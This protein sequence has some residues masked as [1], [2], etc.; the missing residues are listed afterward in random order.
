MT[1]SQPHSRDTSAGC[2]LPG[3]QP[4]SPSV[5]QFVYSKAIEKAFRHQYHCNDFGQPS[6]K[7]VSAVDQTRPLTAHVR[8]L[9]EI[10]N[11][12]MV[13][14]ERLERKRNHIARLKRERADAKVQKGIRLPRKASSM[15][16]A[17]NA[18]T[19]VRRRKQPLK[20]PPISQ[21]ELD[22]G[23]RQTRR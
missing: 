3:D 10:Y 7:Q 6:A 9:P 5:F 18:S 13:T 20:L 17:G 21:K 8:G 2:S 22:S 16:R 23:D 19:R 1:E 15:H 14:R 11:E 4:W 12:Y